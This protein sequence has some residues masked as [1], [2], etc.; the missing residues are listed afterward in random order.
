MIFLNFKD[1]EY[2][3][4]IN[5]SQSDALIVVDVQND[6]MP[7]G[8][9]PVEEGD[10]I[11]DGIN[12]LAK[13]FHENNSPV[14]LTQ[15][16]HPPGHKSFASAHPGKNPGDEYQTEAIGPVLWPDHCVQDTKGAAFHKSLKTPFAKA[17]IRKGTNPEIDSYSAFLEND[18]KTETGLTGMLKS[19]KI[20]RIFICGLALDYCCYFSA[21][22]ATDFGFNVYLLLDLTKGID[23]PEGNISQSLENMKMKGVKF[24][25]INSF[26]W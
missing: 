12:E 15:D 16:W 17:I 23:L 25:N 8:A 2:I 9:L 18:K 13:K 7:G 4:D 3:N 22:D 11:V 21:I 26:S 1:I 10:Q 19:L 14:I 6:F 24:A 20:E 5:I